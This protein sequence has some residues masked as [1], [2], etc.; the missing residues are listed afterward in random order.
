MGD[1]HEFEYNITRRPV[2][3]QDILNQPRDSGE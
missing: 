3:Y 1:L 2:T